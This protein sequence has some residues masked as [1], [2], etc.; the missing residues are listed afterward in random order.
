MKGPVM[1]QTDLA[2]RIAALRLTD[3][4]AQQRASNALFAEAVASAHSRTRNLKRLAICAVV[5]AAI[6]LTPAGASLAETADDLFGGDT[7]PSPA[8]LAE[9]HE[10][11]FDSMYREAIEKARSGSLNADVDPQR[12]E[13]VLTQAITPPTDTASGNQLEADVIKLLEQL[14]AAGDLPPIG[15]GP[16]VLDGPP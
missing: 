5:S 15:T 13:R 3:P 6:A 8:Q 9:R 4:A 16:S 7:S 12:V 10:L 11:R 14:R 1:N 2:A